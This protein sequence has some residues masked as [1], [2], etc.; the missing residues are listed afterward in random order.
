MIKSFK[1]IIIET[2]VIVTVNK[3]VIVKP[4]VIASTNDAY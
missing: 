1:I 3:E 4:D 2:K